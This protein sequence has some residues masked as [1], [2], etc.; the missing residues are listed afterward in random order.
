MYTVTRAVL[1][2]FYPGEGGREMLLAEIENMTT[3]PS[4]TVWGNWEI[5]VYKMEICTV[6]SIL[7]GDL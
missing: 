7:N 3:L 5:L 2:F 1:N 4:L 6:K